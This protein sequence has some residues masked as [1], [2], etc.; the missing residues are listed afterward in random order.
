VFAICERAAIVFMQVRLWMAAY[1]HA[2]VL[3]ILS[4]ER[5]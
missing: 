1:P 5:A 3:A 4:E 2:R